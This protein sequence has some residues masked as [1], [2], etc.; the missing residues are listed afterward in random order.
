MSEAIQSYNE[1]TA[2]IATANQLDANLAFRW[3]EPQP[4]GPIQKACYAATEAHLAMSSAWKS[5]RSLRSRDLHHQ[6]QT[7]LIALATPIF[8]DCVW[9]IAGTPAISDSDVRAKAALLLTLLGEESGG[10]CS[11]YRPRG[12]SRR[13]SQ[14]TSF[15]YR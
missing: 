2:P 4:D 10:S 5:I 3:S 9:Q 12:P 1:K 14:R 8:R 15:V 6:S 13:Q 11:R 7:D